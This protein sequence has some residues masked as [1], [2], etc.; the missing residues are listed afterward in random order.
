MRRLVILET[1]LSELI[2][3]SEWIARQ[4]GSV[5]AGHRIIE[6]L[7][8]ECESIASRPVQLG[9]SADTEAPGLGLRRFPH[10]NF[11]L[12]LRYPDD[13]TLEVFTILWGGRDRGRY[14]N[15]LTQ[16]KQS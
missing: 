10:K 16:K 11:T 3:I 13:Q 9:V 7:Y 8:Q 15:A 14:F 6:Q 1:A 5:G 2:A 12:Y 4:S